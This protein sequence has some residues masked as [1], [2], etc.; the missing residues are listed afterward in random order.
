MDVTAIPLGIATADAAQLE[1]EARTFTFHRPFLLPLFL[2][3]QRPSIN[4]AASFC[5]SLCF[6]FQLLAANQTNF[7]LAMKKKV[8]ERKSSAT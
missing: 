3:D 7:V 6:S 5:I 4:C 1:A 2:F 8:C